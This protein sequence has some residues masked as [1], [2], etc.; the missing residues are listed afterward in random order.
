MKYLPLFVVAILLIVLIYRLIP[1]IICRSSSLLKEIR[2]QMDNDHDEQLNDISLKSTNLIT[3][4]RSLL[5]A[6]GISSKKSLLYLCLAYMLLPILL[7]ISGNNHTLLL[8]LCWICLLNSMISAQAKKRSQYFGSLLYKIYRFINMELDSGL[9]LG[10]ILVSLPESANDQELRLALEKMSAAWQLTGDLDLA[11]RELELK[12]GKHETALLANNLRQ[13]LVTG[14][15]GKAF[16]Q[17]ENL[18]FARYVEHVR[19]RSKQ[20]QSAL[21]LCA[22]L[23]L[24]PVMILMLWPIITEMLN[25]LGSIFS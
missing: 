25:S 13:C 18:L 16:A 4:V 19:R 6:A 2:R 9:L 3:S 14:V 22:V 12:F 5:Q 20:L 17:M 7:V 23:A 10:D 11:L 1:A 8:G 24:L 15:A 21:L